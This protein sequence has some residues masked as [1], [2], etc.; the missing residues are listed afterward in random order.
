M[1]RAVALLL[2][3][4][5]GFS[6]L[7]YEVAWQKYLAT[8]LGS[9]SEATAA[10]L[11]LFLGGLSAGYALFGAATRAV[12]ERAER[13]GRAPRLLLLYGSVES[14]IG[15]WALAF[16][17]LFGA[18]QAVSFAIPHAAGGAGFALDVALCALL[19][20]PPTVLMG[21]TIPILTQAM[22]RSL[23]DA[24]R[25]HAFV[26]AFNTAGAFFGALCAGFFLVPALGLE[27]VMFAMGGVNLFAGGVFLALGRHP[28]AVVLPVAP[29][30]GAPVLRGFAAY[31]AVALLS[32][33]AMMTIQT[34]LIRMG[35]L[36]FGAS[37]FTFSMV[38][39]SFV[40]C[41]ALGSFAVSAL[42]RIRP[43]Y[44]VASQW[45]LIVLL[46]M[47][48]QVLPDTPYWAHLLRTFF[49]DTPAAFLPYHFAA[50]L[51]LLFVLALPIG[52]SGA[53]LPLLFHQLRGETG[54]LGAV[55]GRL[56]SWNTL[57][58]LAGALL[59]GYLLLFFF[60]LHQVYRIALGALVIAAG[61]LA[62][63]LLA[64][65]P[66]SLALAVIAP[67]LVGIVILPRWDP[68]RLSSGLFRQRL[69]SATTGMGPA[70]VFDEIGKRL[71]VVFYRDDPTTS[72]AVM[73]PQAQG[74]ALSRSIVNNG[75]SDGSTAADYQTM[76]MAALL[77]ALL[78][79]RVES[80]LV[81][82]LGTGVTAG[83][84]A[85]LPTTRDVTVAEISAGVVGAAPFFDFANFAASKSPK[86]H[87]VRSDAYRLL[88][89][90]NRRF[91]VIA[92]E[93]SNPWVTGVEMLYTREFLEAAK[94]QLAPGG[95][96][97]QW[98]HV[99]EMDQETVALV[100][101]TY[102]SV[103]DRVSVW[104][105]EGYDLLLVGFEDGRHALD[106]DRLAA[107]VA[108]PEYAAPLR[109][110]GI[111]GLPALLAHELLPL[112][113]LEAA[114][115][116]GEIHTLLHPILSYQAA[117]AFFRG[118]GAM[119]PPTVN[120]AARRVGAENSLLRRLAARTGGRLPDAVRDGAVGELCRWRPIECAT[121][122]AQWQHD[123]P[124]S[125]LLAAQ[126]VKQR[127][128]PSVWPEV[129]PKRLA[130]LGEL[131]K[132]LGPGGA[133]GFDRAQSATELF[134]RGY[135]H[136]APFAPEVELRIWERCEDA[137]GRCATGREEVER[138]IG[139]G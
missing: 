6:G 128:A 30:E 61:I 76:A 46:A 20:V 104:F 73:E 82:G 68:L 33:F 131:F 80:A 57:G 110:A 13:A 59:G 78:A 113:V 47:L 60:D 24:T 112:G 108:R 121:H 40:L 124:A 55:A 11:G 35:A 90:S 38:V 56:Y 66:L 93:P 45:T 64:L 98:M 21:G 133:I 97:V 14:G 7:V 29:A 122:L 106:L 126:L 12:V 86:L 10:I 114:H 27:R 118:D 32:G 51:C 4:L 99:Y 19:V 72:V 134:V 125:P 28:N 54:D 39:A 62:L 17:W 130:E 135:A 85:V 9:Q 123:D 41:I 116:D 3:V 2:T 87:V 58:S 102:A 88:R 71:K 26:Y 52:L 44:V 5:T 50:F 81:I 92:S 48:Y 84:L 53:L 37:Q 43:A 34:V 83:E 111:E 23:E 63:R 74:E 120:A 67:A 25:F 117:R 127:A 105:T 103:F 95:I 94:S 132:A 139:G 96:Y 79:D 91:D 77:P 36:A 65:S 101:R 119:L 129:Q 107:R 31:A 138:R 18:V 1:N 69:P 109:R 136:A 42:P 115:L 15:V 89:R 22:A 100:L 16:P 70:A 49:R 8:L 75:K 137:S